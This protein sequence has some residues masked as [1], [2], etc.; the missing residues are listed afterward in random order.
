LLK[1]GT[2]TSWSSLI[3]QRKTSLYL[4]FRPMLNYNIGILADHCGGDV[5]LSLMSVTNNT[6]ISG[7]LQFFKQVY[8]TAKAMFGLSD[9]VTLR[10]N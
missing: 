6:C 7:Y 3:N 1:K 4:A 9:K 5:V 10:G 8:I 2:I